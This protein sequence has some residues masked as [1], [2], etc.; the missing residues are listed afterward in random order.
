MP[1]RHLPALLPPEL[2]EHT[3]DLEPGVSLDTVDSL[4]G[5]GGLALPGRSLVVLVDI[6]KEGALTICICKGVHVR[7]YLGSQ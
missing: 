6:V 1:C 7:T 5:F 3:T 2:D 4:P